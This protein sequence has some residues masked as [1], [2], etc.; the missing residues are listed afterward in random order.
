MNKEYLEKLK[1]KKILV[2]GFARSGY[3]TAK[4]LNKYGIDIIL[5][6]R[7]DLSDNIEAKEL[8]SLGVKVI[9]GSHPI[10]LLENI[11]MIIK[12]PGIPY[13]I[14][15]LKEAKK[16]DIK[17]VTEI[18]VAGS[19]YNNEII[20]ITG[21]NG[22]TTTTTLIYEI[23]KKEI[24]SVKIAGNI[25]YPLIEVMDESEEQDVIVAELSSFQLNG[26]ND[27][28]PSVSV[29]TNLTEAHL[30]YHLSKEEYHNVKKRIFKNQTEEDYLILNI[31]DKNLYNNDDIKANI[32]YY[33]TDNYSD[34]AYLD[35]NWFVFRGEKIFNKNK[36]SLLGEHNLENCINATI[37]AKLK[38]IKTE[39]IQRVLYSFKGVT[40][41][42]QYLGDI[43]EVKY[44]NDSKATNPTST[45]KALSGF[46]KN[47][48]LICGGK[49][50]GT[51]FEELNNQIHKIKVLVCIGESKHILEKLGKANNIKTIL[52]ERVSDATIIASSIAEKKDTILLSPACASWDQYKNFE[53]RGNEFIETF[54]NIKNKS[55][56]YE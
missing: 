38:D 26:I 5:N 15:I 21:T 48:I 47:V 8:E 52:A 34:D 25:G 46:E 32:I 24:D 18:E 10:N 3:K 22:K 39:N 43:N 50:R 36:L 56:S 16:K 9:S 35:G 55:D 29:I 13:N 7:E 1:N 4:I 51:K 19:L 28:K 37:V 49:D 2:L 54:N 30:D 12:N 11:D 45:E 6:A 41:R 17:I 14:E 23:L 44:Y 20:A 42:M 27:F 53:E 31:K 33:N 40:H